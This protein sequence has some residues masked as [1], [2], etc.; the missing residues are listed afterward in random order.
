MGFFDWFKRPRGRELWLRPNYQELPQKEWTEDEYDH[1]FLELPEEDAWAEW[2]VWSKETRP[3]AKVKFLRQ[4]CLEMALEAAKKTDSLDDPR[5]FAC[6]LD[7]QGET[8]EELV[9]LPGTVAGDEHAIFDMYMAP[10]DKNIRGSL[11]SHPDEH[12]FPSDADLDMFDSQ[13]EIHMIL[14]RP[15]GLD[16]WRAYDRRGVPTSLEVV[17]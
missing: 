8:I 17:A 11:H 10:P 7:V 9:L 6:L 1:W 3:H 12:P 14:C 2:D 15:Y 5:E 13:G 16:N 4:S